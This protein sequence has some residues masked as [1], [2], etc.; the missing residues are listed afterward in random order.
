MTMKLEKILKKYNMDLDTA[1]DYIDAKIRLNKQ[2]SS[3]ETG[4]SYS[5]IQR[6]EKKFNKMSH[7][8]RNTVIAHLAIEN[9]ADNEEK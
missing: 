8:E 4:S 9:L 1:K 7:K 3:V 2:E 6:Y 5:T